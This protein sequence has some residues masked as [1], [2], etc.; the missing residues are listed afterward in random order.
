MPQ[1]NP[2]I[3][4]WARETAGLSIEEAAKKLGLSRPDRL[5][6][7]EVGERE[8]SRRQLVNMSE[9]YRRPL[10]T[11][12]LPRPPREKD[13]G[14]DFRSLREPQTAS[15]E[16]LLNTLLR[17]VQARQQIVKSALEEA[18]EVEPLAFVGSASMSQGVD[19]L[20]ASM[21]EVLTIS[22][23]QFRAHKTITDAFAALRAAA[24]KTGVFVLLMG[25]LGTHH[26][27]IDVRVFRGFA[28]ADNV[29]PFVVINEKD[30]RAAW[31]FTLLHELAHIWLGQTGISGYQSEVDVERFCDAVAARF[32]L[33]PSELE[34][35]GASRIIDLGDLVTRIGAFAGARNLSRKM[36]AYNLLSSNLITSRIYKQLSDAFDAERIAQKKDQDSDEGGPNY[37]VVR[38]HRI[39]PGLVSL[40]RRMMASGILSVPKAGTVLGVKPTAVDNLVGSNRA[41]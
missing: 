31:S 25:N 36:V 15:S 22:I 27:D 4:I 10:L 8:P 17:N 2:D 21:R 41:A 40:V 11:F 20:V 16:A 29:A 9:K 12:Y 6:A 23:E 3:L 38:R 24:E 14:Q 18:E 37:Y 5:K 32:L 35:I 19:H 33:D 26:T 13:R 7:L 28:L 30:S 1:V 34:E 39:G